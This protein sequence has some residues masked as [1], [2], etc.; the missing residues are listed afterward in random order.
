M[1]NNLRLTCGLHTHTHAY[2]HIHTHTY[3]HIHTPYIHM[4][5]KV[6][7]HRKVERVGPPTLVPTLY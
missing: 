1:N 2:S 7:T 5:K 4:Q 3:I 6:Q